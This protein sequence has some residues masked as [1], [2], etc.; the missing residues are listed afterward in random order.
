MTAAGLTHGGVLSA[1]HQQGGALCGSREAFSAKGGARELAKKRTC[2]PL[3]ARPA[4]ARSVVDALLVARTLGRR[5]RP[6]PLDRAIIRRAHSSE[7]VKAAYREVA[8][9][10]ICLQGKYEG[11]YSTRAGDGAPRALR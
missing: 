8:E 4:F 1:L 10:M 3:Q 5:R 6:L 9:S 11:T 2:K 7:A